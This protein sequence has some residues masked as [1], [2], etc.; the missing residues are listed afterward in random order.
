LTSESLW[1]MPQAA[2]LIRTVP[3]A[4]WGIGLSTISNGRFAPEISATR[5]VAINPQSQLPTPPGGA[6]FSEKSS[7]RNHVPNLPAGARVEIK[8]WNERVLL[9]K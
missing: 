8:Q 2:T 7:R 3:G 6:A 1:Q 4:G 9:L 5:I